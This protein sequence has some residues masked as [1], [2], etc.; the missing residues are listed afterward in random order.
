[1]AKTVLITGG[2]GKVGKQLVNHFSDNGFK[3]VFTSRTEENIEK[4]KNGRD[5]VIGIKLDLLDNDSVAG[6]L[7]SLEKNNIEVNY[8]INN[9]RCLDFLK[10]E[11]D[12][13]IKRENWLNEYLIDV[14]IP[15]EL[16]IK[17]AEKMPLKK[18]INI[19]SIYGVVTFNPNL[20]GSDY[21]PTMQYSCAKAALIHLTKELAVKLADKNIQVNSISFGG[22]E[23]RVD[24]EFKEKYAKLCPQKRMMAEEEVIGSV[25]FLVSEKSIYITGQNIIIDG[26]W[27]VW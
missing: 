27:C 2:S 6:I 18:I 4:V 14:V 17:L 3:V 15:Y 22:I 8:L 5:N 9:A 13:F 26:G 12:G 21:K 23:G 25:D 16:S 1:M 24:E 20:S 11:K 7:S 19:A 10:T